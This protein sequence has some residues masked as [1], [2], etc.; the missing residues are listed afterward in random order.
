M[1]VNHKVDYTNNLCERELRKFKR[2]QKQSVVLR[3]NSGAEYICDALTMLESAR[4]QHR[5]IYD[6]AE[7]AFDKTIVEKM[8]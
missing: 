8:F 6:I 5:N 4:M 3:S 2:K 1:K 7:A